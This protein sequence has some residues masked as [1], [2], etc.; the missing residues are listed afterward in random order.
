MRCKKVKTEED[1]SGMPNHLKNKSF[2]AKNTGTP[3]T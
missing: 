1:V 2:Y 3:E